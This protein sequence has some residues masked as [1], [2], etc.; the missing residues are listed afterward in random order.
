VKLHGRPAVGDL[1]EFEGSSL[2]KLHSELQNWIYFRKITWRF[3][4]FT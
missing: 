1:T 2:T 4:S 3:S